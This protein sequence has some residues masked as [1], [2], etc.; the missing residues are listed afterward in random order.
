MDQKDGSSALCRRTALDGIQGFVAEHVQVLPGY[1]AAAS[2]LLS[3]LADVVQDADSRC[4]VRR[5]GALRETRPVGS[6]GGTERVERH[7]R[8][9][10]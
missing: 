1:E 8:R 5:A 3:D 7:R 2:P 6:T 10:A 4:R 9:R